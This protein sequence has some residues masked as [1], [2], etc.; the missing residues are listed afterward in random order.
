MFVTALAPSD[1]M[2]SD[3][4][5]ICALCQSL[6]ER[7]ADNLSTWWPMMGSSIQGEPVLYEEVCVEAIYLKN[8]LS[9]GATHFDL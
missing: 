8:F 1:V 3:V 5:R 7:N 4:F 6:L 9:F 2:Y